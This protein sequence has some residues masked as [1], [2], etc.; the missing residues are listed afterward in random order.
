LKTNPDG[1]G[2]VQTVGPL[3][4]LVRPGAETDGSFSKR[5]L[6]IT[7][8]NNPSQVVLGQANSSNAPLVIP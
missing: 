1:S 8:L 7:D 6:I 2:I 5:F 4:V 3:K